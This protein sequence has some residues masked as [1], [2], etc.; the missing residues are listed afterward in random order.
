MS[1]D[2]EITVKGNGVQSG[3]RKLCDGARIDRCGA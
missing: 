1:L 3:K 2:C